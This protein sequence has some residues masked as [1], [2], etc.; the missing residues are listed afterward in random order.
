MRPRPYYLV[1]NLSYPDEAEVDKTAAADEGPG[2]PIQD[3]LSQGHLFKKDLKKTPVT[4]Q[5][6]RLRFT[7]HK[8]ISS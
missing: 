1:D 7:D 3:K 6:G 4:E 5:G 8:K 2:G